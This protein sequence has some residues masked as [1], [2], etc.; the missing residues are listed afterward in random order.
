MTTHFTSKQIKGNGRGKFLG[1]PTIN[2]EIPGDFDLVSGVYAVWV[3]IAGTRLRGAMHYG[4][5]P[6]FDQTK[7]SLEVFLLGLGE[8]ELSHADLSVISVEIKEKLRDV[9]RFPSV[10]ALTRQMEKDVATV[11]KVLSE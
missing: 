4:P 9:I 6:T 10:D 5:I 7:K 8:H 2:M 1:Y 3:T 11:R